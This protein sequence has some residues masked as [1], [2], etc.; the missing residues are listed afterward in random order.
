[1]DPDAL[2]A[3][4]CPIDGG[5]FTGDDRRLVCSAG[6]SFDLARQGYVN[7]AS[8]GRRRAKVLSDDVAMVSARERFL[9]TGGFSAI[10]EAVARRATSTAST[11]SKRLI[12]ELG[13]G[14]AAYLRTALD[15][16]PQ[17]HG[18]AVD[19]SVP[20]TIRASRSHERTTAIVADSWQP[21]PIADS[22]ADAV[23]VA[24]APRHLPE[25]AR[26]LRPDGQ[27]VL[28]SALPNHLQELRD[29]FG[30]L[31]VSSKNSARL[32]R[33]ATD[34]GLAMREQATVQFTLTLDR[35]AT[36][37]LILMGPNA[38]HVDHEQLRIQIESGIDS[39]DVTVAVQ[40]ST[41]ARIETE[42]DTKFSD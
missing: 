20:A 39:R 13:A 16:D 7:L 31:S 6:H 22:C 30:L 4:R 12:V 41:F 23:I 33:S 29:Q 42:E 1:M 15:S 19:L 18:I 32:E 28:A 5:S 34:V 10:R 9:A 36:A 17:A 21:L 26:I 37:D 8:T 40:V 35:Q 38:W 2:E 14:T 3:L 24:F 11:R 25:I 27:L